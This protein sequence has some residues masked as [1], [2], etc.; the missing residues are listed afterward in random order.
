M[1]ILQARILEWV[2]M[3]SSR[4]SS[5]P[6]D[7]TR[8]LHRR[9]LLYSSATREAQLDIG[10][11]NTCKSVILSSNTKV[12]FRHESGW[13][14]SSLPCEYLSG[15]GD[16]NKRRECWTFVKI[17]TREY[18]LPR[19]KRHSA[20]LLHTLTGSVNRIFG[21]RNRAWREVPHCLAAVTLL[22]ASPSSP[23]IFLK[24]LFIPD[25]KVQFWMWP[26][27]SKNKVIL[28]G[29]SSECGGWP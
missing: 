15:A 2:A 26:A 10:G 16:G 5:P 13:H 1:G 17:K 6:R 28:L 23:L 29:L 3:P 25:S 4:G 9:Q 20:C 19:L 22:Q 27:A 14:R 21:S 11:R 8:L 18:Y 7:Q 12:L 24:S